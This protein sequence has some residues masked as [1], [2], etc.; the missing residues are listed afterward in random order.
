MRIFHRKQTRQLLIYVLG[1]L[2][3][4]ILSGCALQK[5][6]KLKVRADYGRTQADDPQ[7]Q[8]QAIDDYNQALALYDARGKTE[9]VAQINTVLAEM[10][11]DDEPAKARTHWLKAGFAWEKEDKLQQAH[12]AYQQ[13]YRSF[14]D[15]DY[16][17]KD[18]EEIL[19]RLEKLAI[20]MMNYEQQFQ[21]VA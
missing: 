16:P 1:L 7:A 17:E 14:H 2:F 12:D 19:L 10:L 4:L 18:L 21:W 8:A 13:W 11:M 3:S 15:Q 9:E 20:R 5:A 6:H